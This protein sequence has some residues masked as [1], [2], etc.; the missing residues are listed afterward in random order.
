[1]EDIATPI[2]LVLLS[3]AATA[4]IMWWLES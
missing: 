4:A 1:M 3:F 2:V